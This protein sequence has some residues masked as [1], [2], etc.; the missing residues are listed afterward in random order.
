M[1]NV[2]KLVNRAYAK[3]YRMFTVEN[4][5][6]DAI[7]MM[8][9]LEKKGYFEEDTEDDLVRITTERKVVRLYIKNGFDP[10]Y[11]H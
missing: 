1:T 7:N 11:E 3:A 8:K 10:Y 4:Y 5:D 2:K 9:T 6:C